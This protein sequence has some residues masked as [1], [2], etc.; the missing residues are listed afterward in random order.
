[1]IK[2]KR[3]K[4]IEEYVLENQSASLDE[5]MKV[6]N[7]S[8]NTI[9]RD[10]QE[11]VE[12]GLFK[13]VYGGIAVAIKHN[14]LESVEER[15]VRNQAGKT[16]IGQAAT[17]FLEDGDI[18]FIDSGTTTIEMLGFLKDKSLTV[19]TNNIDFIVQ[20]LPYESLNI[21]SIGGILERKTNSLVGP[22][23]IGILK[24]YN[25]NKAFM[26]TTGVSLSNGVTNASPLETELKKT[27]VQRSQKVFL[28]ADQNK[29]GK[30]GLMTYCELK[31]IDCLITDKLPPEEFQ[32]FAAEQQIQLVNA[33][34]S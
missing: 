11:L 27:I 1:M 29:F 14:K 31:D 13:K 23:N 22:Q 30:Y 18:I 26:A 12:T 24:T 34:Q 15:K 17:T 25:I 4:K 2:E 7:V 28:L 3:V 10:V 19:V 20:A 33:S 5:L 8:I 32:E 21:I 6:F 9:R 16:K